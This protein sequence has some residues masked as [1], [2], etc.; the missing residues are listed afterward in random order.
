MHSNAYDCGS[1]FNNVMSA[2]VHP[3]RK[4]NRTASVYPVREQN[5]TTERD[6]SLF[7]PVGTFQKSLF[8]TLPSYLVSVSATYI[9]FTKFKCN[10]NLSRPTFNIMLTCYV[11]NI[12]NQIRTISIKLILF[13]CPHEAQF[14]TTLTGHSTTV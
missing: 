4:Q 5:G 1:T 3:V 10:S 12:A 9:M 13:S 2:S 7:V 8:G 14:S 11:L 6:G